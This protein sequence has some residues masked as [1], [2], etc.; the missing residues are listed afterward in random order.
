MTAI[1]D[2]V[3]AAITQIVRRALRGIGTRDNGR[4]RRLEFQQRGS[5]VLR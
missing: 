2:R 1:D 3:A 5:A 4:G